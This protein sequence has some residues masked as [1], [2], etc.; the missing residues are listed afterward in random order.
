MESFLKTIFKGRQQK[1]KSDT[2]KEQEGRF[3]T[4]I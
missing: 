3:K 2:Q 1:A 4:Y